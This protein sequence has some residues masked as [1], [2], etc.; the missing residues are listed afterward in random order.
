MKKILSIILIFAAFSSITFLISR[1]IDSY[2]STVNDA[3]YAKGA[4]LYEQKCA[5]C[6]QSSGEGIEGLYPPL[7]KSDFL[8][9]DKNKIINVLLQGLSGH[10]EVN[11]KVFT[12]VMH[13]VT[14]TDDELSDLLNYVY[15][16]FGNQRYAFT[17]QEIGVLRELHS[18]HSSN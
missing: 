18:S 15:V 5:T 11:G 4:T 9:H 2:Q 3:K 12:G 14:G 7:Q 6:H 8:H 13:P 10:I 17:P 1:G 16:R